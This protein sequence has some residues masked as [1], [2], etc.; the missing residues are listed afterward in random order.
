[1]NQGKA[2]FPVLI[3]LS[4]GHLIND[5]IQSLLPA[6]YPIIKQ[7]YNLD[8]GQIGLLTLT[9]QLAACIFQPLVGHVN[10]KK[11][12]PYSIVTG[13]AFSLAGLLT[14]A[15]ALSFEAL[16]VGATLVGLGSS[17]FHPEATR[18]ARQASGGQ[19]GMAQAI[20]V[21][22]GQTGSAIGPLLAAFII[23]PGGQTSIAW[24]SMIAMIGAMILV[25]ACRRFVA[26]AREAV[27]L[28]KKNGAKAQPLQGG[29][30]QRVIWSVV[31]LMLL[32][33]SK[34]AYSA[35]FNSFYTFYLIEKFGVS[36]QASQ[37]ML[38]LFLV[39]S[40]FGSLVGGWVGDK[41]GRTF[42]IWFSI[43]GA[44]PFTLILPHVDLFWTAI[45]TVVI[46]VIMS[47][48]LS[49][50]IVYAMELM[51]GRTGMIGGLFYGLAFGFGGLSAAALGFIADQ[52]SIDTVYHLC[53]YLPALGLL[54]F[55]LPKVD[56]SAPMKKA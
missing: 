54:A 53:A 10:D 9:F 17:I 15:Y 46:N 30:R 40:A 48:A 42:I 37:Y 13:M 7:V 47:S 4:L 52:T 8:F 45:L 24:F 25:W 18:M 21:V 33:L 14:L 12:M 29:A 5:T 11:P 44:L 22:G 36:M 31:I 39:A 23:V 32:L 35:S 38:F 2:L 27:A 19:L 26:A 20:F 43:V 34:T 51:P 50:I 1:M 41:F 3:A 55:W 56:H 16:L 28:A 6:I 49:S